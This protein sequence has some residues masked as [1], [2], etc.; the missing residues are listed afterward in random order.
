MVGWV[1]CFH[2]VCLTEGSRVFLAVNKSLPRRTCKTS[3]TSLDR[4][5][6]TRISRFSFRCAVPRCD[7]LRYRVG[8][9]CNELLC[10]CFCQQG[11]LQICSHNKHCPRCIHLVRLVI[12]FVDISPTS[13]RLCCLC[14]A[15]IPSNPSN[16]CVNCIRGQIDITEGIPKQVTI[17]WCKKCGR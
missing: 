15:H 4:T 3:K 10:I 17:H 6:F 5:R 13:L 12:P 9:R 1:L 16:M 11:V 7:A 8:V 14:G 2:R